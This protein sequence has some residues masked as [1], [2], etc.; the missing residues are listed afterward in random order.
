MPG[1]RHDRILIE[2]IN[3]FRRKKFFTRPTEYVQSLSWICGSSKDITS[4]HVH[5]VQKLYRSGTGKRSDRPYDKQKLF[6][7]MGESVFERKLPMQRAF[8]KVTR[9]RRKQNFRYQGKRIFV[10]KK[11]QQGFFLIQVRRFWKKSIRNGL[12]VIK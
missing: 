1:Y 2:G 10:E 9:S 5:M 12:I 7:S 8:R 4:V 11:S 3:P 6:G